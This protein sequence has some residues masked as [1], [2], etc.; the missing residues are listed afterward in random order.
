MYVCG[1]QLCGPVI[2]TKHFENCRGGNHWAGDTRCKCWSQIS[3]QHFT[4]IRGDCRN[5][6]IFRSTLTQ[7]F[8][9][10]LPTK[11]LSFTIIVKNIIFWF[12]RS[13]FFN[14]LDDES[15][16]TGEVFWGYW[17]LRVSCSFQITQIFMDRLLSLFCD[18]GRP[19]MPI[20]NKQAR[21]L[22]EAGEYWNIFLLNSESYAPQTW[23]HLDRLGGGNFL[24]GW[25]PSIKWNKSQ[26][27]EVSSNKL[28]MAAERNS[29]PDIW[30]LIVI[31]FIPVQR[32]A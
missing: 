26:E 28:E 27:S 16:K 2:S 21:Y 22:D 30:G 6:N 12:F 19:E 23:K 8:S 11:L 9:W 20:L 3:T 29:I 1:Q 15:K 25:A 17:R 18:P 5:V 14:C 13:T 10:F 7:D 32:G 24:M 31:H 4:R